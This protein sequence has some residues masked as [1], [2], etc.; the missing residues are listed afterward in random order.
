MAAT[1]QGN[2]LTRTEQDKM[3]RNKKRFRRE[4]Q[5]IEAAVRTQRFGAFGRSR[6][7][8]CPVCSGYHVGTG[9]KV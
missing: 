8:R 4:G 6:V 5:A 9:A 3:C 7:Y 1:A 2:A